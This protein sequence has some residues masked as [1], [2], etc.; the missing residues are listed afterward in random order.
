MNNKEFFL[1]YGK[2]TISFE[3]P[4]EL[5]LYDIKGRNHPPSE[6]LAEAYLSA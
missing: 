3:I 5:L 4:E 1:K 6:D 2:K